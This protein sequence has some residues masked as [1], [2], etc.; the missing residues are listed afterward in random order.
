MPES[1]RIA[2]ERT[3]PPVG[4]VS[5]SVADRAVPRLAQQVEVPGVTGSLFN[6][7]HEDP[8]EGHLPATGRNHAVEIGISL[9]R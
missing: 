9:S 4:P 7:V 5:G 2:M 1:W 8:S 6:H 3:V